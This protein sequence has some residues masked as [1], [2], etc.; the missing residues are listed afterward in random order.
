MFIYFLSD[1]IHLLRYMQGEKGVRLLP[2]IFFIWLL[3]NK[4]K[5]NNLKSSRPWKLYKKQHFPEIFIEKVVYKSFIKF[6]CTYS[7][8]QSPLQKCFVL[9]VF[10]NV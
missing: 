5:S 3:I 7:E 10:D 9:G 4:L 2:H 8:N 1:V 6:S